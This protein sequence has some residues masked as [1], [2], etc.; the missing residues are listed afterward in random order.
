MEFIMKKVRVGRSIGTYEVPD[1]VR[2]KILNLH[3]KGASLLDIATK[4]TKDGI[5][6]ARGGKWYQ[7][8]I[9]AILHQMGISTERYKVTTDVQD[10]IISM[11]SR[12]LTVSRITTE[13]TTQGHKNARGQI[14][15]HASTVSRI[16]KRVNDEDADLSQ[17]EK[18]EITPDFN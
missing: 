14:K 1:N 8:T 16:I 5:P 2:R 11:F 10:E 3:R 12:G 6:T 7:G 13:L 15:W 18:H 17:I 9:R 4:L